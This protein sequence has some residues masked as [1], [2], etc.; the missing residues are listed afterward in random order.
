[1]AAGRPTTYS[2]DMLQRTKEYLDGGYLEKSRVIPSV[3]GL[4]RYLDVSRSTLYLWGDDHDEFSDIL[5][6]I[7]D[8]QHEILVTSGLTGDFNPTMAKLMLTKHGYSDKQELT[9]NEG[10][11]IELDTHWTIEV[12]ET[13]DNEE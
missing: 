8:E 1:M 3:V 7:K 5:D 13:K 9:G 11:P 2:E 12:V 6:S 4:A 10:G